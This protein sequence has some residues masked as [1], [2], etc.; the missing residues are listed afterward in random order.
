MFNPLKSLSNQATLKYQRGIWCRAITTVQLRRELLAEIKKNLKKLNGLDFDWDEATRHNNMVVAL[1]EGNNWLQ[2]ARDLI[3]SFK[4]QYRHDLI[5]AKDVVNKST[6]IES[7]E[8][9]RKRQFLI[10]SVQT[11]PPSFQK[12]KICNLN[13]TPRILISPFPTCA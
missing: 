9:K 6:N 11:P 13:L 1:E 4:M 12:L 10:E 8:L 5:D 2:H 7:I 3:Y